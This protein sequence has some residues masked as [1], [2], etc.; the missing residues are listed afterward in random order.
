MI[1]QYK[2]FIVF[3][4]RKKRIWNKLFCFPEFNNLKEMQYWL[5]KNNIFNFNYKKY[6]YKIH[7]LS[8]LK[9]KMIF[10]NIKIKK[11]IKININK[12]KCWYNLKKKI[13]IG[14]PKPIYDIIIQ[15]HK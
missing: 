13:H 14:I 1:L 2:N 4:N 7:K 9:I 5:L 12:N 3:E 15:L 6:F 11:K 8:H 10:I